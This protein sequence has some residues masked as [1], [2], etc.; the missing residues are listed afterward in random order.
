MDLVSDLGLLIVVHRRQVK[1]K[2]F[3]RPHTLLVESSLSSPIK[4]FKAADCCG[5]NPGQPTCRPGPSLSGTLRGHMSELSSP[6]GGGGTIMA[7]ILP[8][9][10]NA[11]L[12]AS[13]R[14]VTCAVH[15]LSMCL[16]VVPAGLSMNAS[17]ASHASIPCM[18]GVEHIT[19][20]PHTR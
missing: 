14:Y 1:V 5:T 15:V 7:S 2:F 4:G 13:Q 3:K 20:A 11:A 9:D 6:L 10:S 17:H 18:L 19:S 16:L 12:P 8:S